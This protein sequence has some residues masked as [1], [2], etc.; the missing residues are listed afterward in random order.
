[1]KEMSVDVLIVV[2][3]PGAAN[4]IIELPIYLEK[5]GVSCHIL[6]CGH[7]IKFLDDRGVDFTELA[8]ESSPGKFLDSFLPRLLLLGTSQNPDSPTH[9]F[10]QEARKRSII[11]AG[12]VDMAVDASLRFNGRTDNPL[13]YV[14]EY[15]LVP[16]RFTKEA[17]ENL[18]FSA[19]R[20]C[21][22][23]HPAY[24]RVRK[25]A[26]ELNNQDITI[27]RTE[28]IGSDPAPRPVWLFAAEHVDGCEYERMHFGPGYT[29]F[30]RGGSKRR[31]DIVLEEV[32]DIVAVMNPRPFL[33]LRLHPKNTNE[34]FSVYY[35]EIDYVSTGGNPLDLIWASDLVI[36]LSSMLL[37]EAVHMGKP[38]LS[39]V[40]RKE[41][42]D[43]APSVMLNLTPCVS[44]RKDLQEKMGSQELYNITKIPEESSTSA[45]QNLCDSI[46]SLLSIS[47]DSS[48]LLT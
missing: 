8:R 18:G 3:D 37:M 15:L 35:P 14:P 28:L 29:L 6:A 40:P 30:G 38:T 43:W 16:D 26:S 4:F 10:M 46:S 27:I 9:Q 2:E 7:A 22:C 32:L 20:I 44:T 34:E 41:E 12:F 48:L 33:I 47:H 17:F 36:G 19:E 13:E 23:G 21:V 42:Y 39:I 31:T 11:S 45:V 24:D 1:M 5:N 25:R